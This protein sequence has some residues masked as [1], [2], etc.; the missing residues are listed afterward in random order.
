MIT[1]LGKLVMKNT[2]SLTNSKIDNGFVKTLRLS[3]M[4]SPC[5]TRVI[6]WSRAPKGVDNWIK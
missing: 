6:K 5:M 3:K 2:P 1:L 4:N